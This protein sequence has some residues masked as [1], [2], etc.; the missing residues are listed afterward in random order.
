[1][2][3]NENAFE[4]ELAKLKNWDQKYEKLYEPSVISSKANLLDK[5]ERYEILEARFKSLNFEAPRLFREQKRQLERRIYPNPII[6]AI[7]RIAK[8]IFKNS[9]LSDYDLEVKRSFKRSHEQI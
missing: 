6:R 9:H 1:M 8:S 3:G 5:L 7:F 2:D 4:L